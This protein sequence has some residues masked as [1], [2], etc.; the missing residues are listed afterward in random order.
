MFLFTNCSFKQDMLLESTLDL[1]YENKQELEIV[2]EHYQD[3]PEKLRA[4]QFII[5]NMIGK[6]VIDSS[7]IKNMQPFYDALTNH[8]KKYGGYD[9]MYNIPYAIALNAYIQTQQY[10]LDTYRIFRN[11]HLTF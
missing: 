2:L 9:M 6:Q 3:D 11:C 4:A 1:A 7:S 8:H 5:K 10:S